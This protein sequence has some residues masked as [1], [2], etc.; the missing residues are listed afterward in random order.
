VNSNPLHP[1]TAQIWLRPLVAALCAAVGS[2][3]AATAVAAPP[4]R[5]GFALE[6]SAVPEAQILRGGPPRDGIR[7]L[8][9]PRA[10]SA[11]EAPWD[12]DEMVVGVEMGGEARAYPLA[13]LN[14]HE[15]VN[16]EV[17][18]RPILVS[19][20]PLCGSALVFDR[21]VDGRTLHFGVS[22]LLYQ[23][24]LLMFDRETESLWSQL[25]AKAETG[26]WMGRRL[27][28]LRSRIDRWG[29]WKVEHPGTTVLARPTGT[30]LAY[31]RDPY[32]QYASSGR[33]YFPV[34]KADERYHPKMP[35]VGLRA[36]DGRARAYPAA[37]LR[38]AGGF[39]VDD[40]AG[41]HVRVAYDLDE[42]V[43]RVEAPDS[44]EVIEGYWF[45]WV[46]FH[47]DTSVYVAPEASQDA[48]GE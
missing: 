25:A 23:S 13:I 8:D 45:A 14:W 3:A 38:A 12:P 36:R 24:N 1:R 27:A 39:V 11:A 10:V 18:G 15:L 40:F 29:H 33:L 41:E 35:V 19:F 16:D 28:L 9:G 34:Q 7:A 5:N 17:G 44:L 21:R 47:P 37:E 48:A 20:C 2:A 32:D 46:T 30:E 22:G 6:P 43:F 42:K 26:E 4:T 31:D